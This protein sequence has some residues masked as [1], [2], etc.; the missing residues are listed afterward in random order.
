MTP[1]E[2]LETWLEGNPQHNP[3]TDECCPDF[4]CCYP[5]LLASRE[6][7]EAFC[8]ANKEDREKMLMMFLGSS[9]AEILPDVDVHLAGDPANYTEPQ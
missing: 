1:D 6:V 7:R 8:Q 2:Q 5:K 4:S 3:T 9:L